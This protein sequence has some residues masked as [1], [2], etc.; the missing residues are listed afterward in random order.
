MRIEI[1]N[2]L[3]E[4]P[5]HFSAKDKTF[6]LLETLNELTQF[7]KINCGEYKRVIDAIYPDFNHATKIED[8]PYIP[9]RLFKDYDLKSIPISETIRTLTSSGT[10]SQKVSKICLDKITA[11]YQTKVL[12]NIL[13]TFLGKHRLP[14]LILDS[15]H[16]F[17]N[18]DSFSARGAGILGL[19]NFGRD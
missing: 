7:H 17:A 6:I 16:V 15:Q 9:V 12:A 10:T 13:K 4:N 2:L 8:I 14:M 1:E 19:S 5:Y 11:S 3:N 18:R